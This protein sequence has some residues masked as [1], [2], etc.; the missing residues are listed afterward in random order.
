MKICDGHVIGKQPMNGFKKTTPQ[1]ARQPL[2]AV[3]SHVFGLF[4]VPSFDDNK[5][6]LTFLMN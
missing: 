4:D 5:Y 3:H 2:G 1:R 6:F